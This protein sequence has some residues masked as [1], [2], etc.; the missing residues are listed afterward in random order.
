MTVDVKSRKGVESGLR[1]VSIESLQRNQF[2]FEGERR[3][4]VTDNLNAL[5]R[6]GTRRVGHDFVLLQDAD[7]ENEYNLFSERLADTGV[8]AHSK[9]DQV[10]GVPQLMQLIIIIT[11]IIIIMS[12]TSNLNITPTCMRIHIR[13][14]SN[15]VRIRIEAIR[16]RPDVFVVVSGEQVDEDD[17]ALWY[18]IAHNRALSAN[19]SRSRNDGQNRGVSQHLADEGLCVQHSC[20]ICA[21]QTARRANSWGSTACQ[22]SR[23]GCQR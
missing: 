21:T 6:E 13:I 10:L 5:L 15:E 3:V 12:I 11:L 22:W 2:Y 18:D 14:P 19:L 9:R 1:E 8:S 20:T 23:A 7:Q 17:G 4:R 16:L